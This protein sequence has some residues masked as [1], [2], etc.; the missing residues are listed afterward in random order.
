MTSL[1]VQ[2]NLGNQV[3]WDWD[4]FKGFL[5]GVERYTIAMSVPAQ[6]ITGAEKNSFDFWI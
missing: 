6:V 2:G 3:R 5:S 4:G 1:N